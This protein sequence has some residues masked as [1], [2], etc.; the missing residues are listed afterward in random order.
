MTKEEALKWWYAKTPQQ[1]LR[2][3][4]EATLDKWFEQT[5]AEEYPEEK[6][7]EKSFVSA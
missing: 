5:I 4:G 3:I 2:T 1:K 7:S 6:K